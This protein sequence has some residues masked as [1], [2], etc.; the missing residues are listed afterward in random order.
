[1]HY[2]LDSHYSYAVSD[3]RTNDYAL[4]LGVGIGDWGWQAALFIIKGN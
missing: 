2:Y 3:K 4:F 1:M